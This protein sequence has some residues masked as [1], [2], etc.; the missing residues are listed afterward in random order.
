VKVD[1]LT[2]DEKVIK[3]VLEKLPNDLRETDNGQDKAK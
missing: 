3:E 1:V 2:T